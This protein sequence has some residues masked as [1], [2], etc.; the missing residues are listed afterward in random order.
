MKINITYLFLLF[1]T[2]GF[3]NAQ[4]IE[5]IEIKGQLLANYQDL[6]GVTV[7]NT[8]S[9][10]GVITNAEGKF[11]INATLNDV[12][13]ISALQFEK[14]TV[15]IDKKILEAKSMTIFMVEKINKLDEVLILPYGLSGNLST[16]VENFK[17]LSPN[18]DALYFGLGN[19]EQFDFSD[20]YKT[21]VRNIAIE[22]SHL[23]YGANFTKIIGNYIAPLFK[24]KQE[25]SNVSVPIHKSLRELHTTEYLLKRLDIPKE[26]IEQFIS[27]VEANGIDDKLLEEGN[28]FLLLEHLINQSKLFSKK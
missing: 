13:E 22:S 19:I 15:I 28:E 3:V 23:E 20:D 17:D 8:S 7:F 4:E 10:R 1:F 25:S 18:L 21:K 5:R 24:K 14:F 26:E 2:L 16:D 9:N 12:I 27:F 6:E 11:A